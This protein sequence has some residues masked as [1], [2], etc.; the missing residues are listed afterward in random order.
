MFKEELVVDYF[1]K[2][3][4]KKIEY[5][6]R[7]LEIEEIRNKAITIVGPRRVGKTYFLLNRFF[8]DKNKS[9]YVDFESFEFSDVGPE[10]ILRLIAIYAT[11]YSA[12]VENLFLDEI[13]ALK[14]W[15]KAVRSLLNR[16][17]NIFLSGSSS[18]L[19]P[20]E[21]STELRGRSISYLL[22]P[23][24]FTEFLR[25]R[26]VSIKE[27]LSITEIEMLKGKLEEYLVYGGYPEV[28]FSHNKE[29]ILK[30]YFETIFY[31]D[32]VERHEIKSISTAKVIFEYLFQ[33]NSKE[34]NIEKIKN[35]VESKINVKTKTTIY[36]YID[37]I[38]DTLSV[39]FVDRFSQSVYKRKGWPKKVYVC[40][41]GISSVLG[42]S[43]DYS[44]RMENV[45]FLEL[46]RKTNKNPLMEIYYFKNHQ[47]HEVDF[48]VKEGLN[49]VQLIQV[50]YAGARDEIEEREIKALLKASD[51][52]KCKNL[53][54]VTWNYEDELKFNNKV[55]KCIPLWK[56]LIR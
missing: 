39:F 26:N 50:T 5:V 2:I 1:E 25:A 18:K 23:F 24:S 28:V 20:K 16:G 47:Q 35:F 41:V 40:D 56:W 54:I 32:F 11:R 55:I 22:L 8:R 37:K 51:V 7:E 45:V 38:S 17:Y 13:Q 3:R 14:E 12:K 33:N 48:V 42:F 21:L 34:V 27:L 10:D 9:I 53:L 15:P 19:L 31:K 46:L 43:K 36:S 6:E 30:E 44:K 52:L 49:I 29:K 4:E